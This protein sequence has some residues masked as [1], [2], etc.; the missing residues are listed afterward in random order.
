MARNSENFLP[1]HARE[2]LKSCTDYDIRNTVL[3]T[4]KSLN[5]TNYIKHEFFYHRHIF[6]GQ[7]V[8]K[9]DACEKET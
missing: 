7:N 8:E 4:V 9:D 1:C 3:H 2:S 5:H 6:D